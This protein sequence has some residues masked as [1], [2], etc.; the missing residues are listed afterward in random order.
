MCGENDTSGPEVG[1]FEGSPP[2]VRGKHPAD[3]EYY[4]DTRITPACAGKTA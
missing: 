1:R 2:H 3:P 4:T